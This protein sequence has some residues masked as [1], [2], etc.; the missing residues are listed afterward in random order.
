[1]FLHYIQISFRNLNKYKTQTFI[2]ICAM[3]V[4]LT[5]M[6]IVS[7]VMLSY[8]TSSLLSQS[9]ADRVEQFAHDEMSRTVSSDDKALILGHQFNSVKEIHQSSTSVFN[10][11]ASAAPSGK[12]EQ[13][14]VVY[15]VLK[16]PGYFRFLG[17]KSVYSGERLGEFKRNEVVITDWLAKKLFDKENP[18]GQTISLRFPYLSKLTDLKEG[19][20]IVKDV[21]IRPSTNNEFIF[22]TNQIFI[23]TDNI[24][25]D[26]SFMYFV[27]RDGASRDELQKE[28]S[29]LLPGKSFLLHNVKATYDQS[30]SETFRK[31]IILFLFVFVLVSF[32][33]Y[34]RQQAQLFRLRE[35]EVAL[36]T[37]IGSQPMSLFVLFATEIMIVLI[38]TIA[39]SLILIC[40]ITGFLN[41]NYN[42]LIEDNNYSFTESYPIALI[43]AAILIAIGML[44]AFI[45]VRRIRRD[46]TGL[47]MRMRPQPK[48]RFRNVGLIV[49]MTISILFLW[50]TSLAFLSI[51]SIRNWYGIPEDTDRYERALCIKTNWLEKEDTERI[52]ARIDTLESVERIFSYSQS[53]SLFDPYEGFPNLSFYTEWFQNSDDIEEFFNLE[54]KELPGKVNPDRYILISEDFKQM[55]IDKNLWNGKTLTLPYRAYG[56][57]E[58]KGV[59]DNLPLNEKYTRKTMIVTDRNANCD[60]CGGE[61]SR[62]I[63]PK[64]G[65]ESEA[66]NSID[67]IIREV[68]PARVDIKTDSYFN[69][70]APRQYSM[71]RAV[72]TIIYILSVISVIT[73]VAAVYSGVSLD[74]RRRRKE[75]AL[76][77]LNGAGPKVIAMIFARTYIVIIAAAA[78]IALPLGLIGIPKLVEYD[79]L[80]QIHTENIVIPY[81]II[82]LIVI[83]VTALTIARKIRD[84]MYA[85]PIEY[86]KE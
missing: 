60:Q 30:R 70:F 17:E 10:I 20:F 54:I 50:L 7:S 63:L 69:L 19:D 61:L 66:K 45:T 42:S 28:L 75:M 84:I 44:V 86:L 72:I 48:Y 2:S 21:I 26:P 78:L 37:C 14:L 1:M 71:I 74:T 81:L 79:I 9:Y 22:L 3:A 51:D 64:A 83:T 36:R 6:A 33:N 13:S 29:D 38:F 25:D 76:R 24:P 58:I 47:A 55:L 41:T 31:L 40:V 85:D 62:I 59:Y 35:R 82:I 46:Q 32:T 73:T 68:L 39:L 5:L 34:I 43:S 56:E 23:F 65:K 15:G 49:Q 11:M 8:K 16:D 27:L 18:I 52:F 12:D 80:F 57:Y 4:S 53:M 67:D 77:K